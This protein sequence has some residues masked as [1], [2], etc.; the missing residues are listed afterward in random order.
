M[1]SF[2]VACVAIIVIAIGAVIALD[3]Y[4]QAADAAFAAPASVRI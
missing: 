3:K 2:L 4:Q 1:K